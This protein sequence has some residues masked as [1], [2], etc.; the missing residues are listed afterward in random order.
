MFYIISSIIKKISSLTQ[1]TFHLTVDGKPLAGSVPFDPLTSFGVEK[2]PS[3]NLDSENEF[4]QIHTIKWVS[5]LL[6][7][8]RVFKKKN[9]IKGGN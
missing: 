1:P 6:N 9:E 7:N 3:L 5:E 2:F 4:E 8:I